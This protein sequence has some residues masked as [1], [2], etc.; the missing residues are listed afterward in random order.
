MKLCS[1]RGR[2]VV[3]EDEPFSLASVTALCRPSGRMPM[4]SLTYRI[5]SLLLFLMVALDASCSVMMS[6]P[7]S[8]SWDK[9]WSWRAEVVRIEDFSSLSAVLDG[10]LIP[11]P[12]NLAGRA[13][14]EH[15]SSLRR[16]LSC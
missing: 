1:A 4:R 3:Q 8:L 7:Y 14:R 10:M 16:G 15:S 13:N 9:I 5:L 2:A 12:P 11:R 6:W